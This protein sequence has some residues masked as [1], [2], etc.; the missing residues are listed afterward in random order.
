MLTRVRLRQ[1][2]AQSGRGGR[3]GGRGGEEGRAEE[4]GVLGHAG[5]PRISWAS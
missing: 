3:G 5:G 2:E 1:G 4:E